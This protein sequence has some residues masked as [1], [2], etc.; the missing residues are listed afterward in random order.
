[1]ISS[2][3][4]LFFFIPVKNGKQYIV[5]GEYAYHHYMQDNFNDDGWG[6]AYRSFQTVFSWY[7]RQGY[8][9]KPVPTHAQIQQCLIDLDDKP[10]T[11]LNSRQWIGSMEVSMCLQH[12]IGVDARIMHV[13]SGAEMAQHGP[14]LAQH[15]TTYGTPVM[16]GGGVLAHTI[17]G[18]DFNS[19]TND[20]RFLVLDPHYTGTDDLATVQKKG[21]CGWKPVTFWDKKSYYNFCMPVFPFVTD[22]WTHDIRCFERTAYLLLYIR[23]DIDM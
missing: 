12:F 7:Q 13:R 11:F 21:W 23:L 10:K 6:C 9:N 4:F 2:F 15:F 1:M 18:V 14:T 8:T 5:K 16:I 19:E 3:F 17:I 22:Y 20:L